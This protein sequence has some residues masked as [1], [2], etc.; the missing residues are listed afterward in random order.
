MSESRVRI[1]SEGALSADDVARRT[2]ATSRRGFDPSDVRGFLEAVAGELRRL[3][4]RIEELEG[5]GSGGPAP[6]HHESTAAPALDIATLTTALG[7]ETARVLRTAQEAA[8]DVRARAEEGAA[9]ALA[10]AHDEAARIRAAAETLLAQRTE[11][12]DAMAAKLRAE[13]ET[14]VGALKSRAESETEAAIQAAI[15]RGREMVGEAQA[16]RERMLTDLA[17]RRRTALGQLEMLRAGRDRLLAAY[18]SVRSSLEEVTAQLEQADDG[19]PEIGTWSAVAEH[20]VAEH[21]VAELAPPPAAPTTELAPPEPDAVAVPPV[22]VQPPAPAVA[23][24]PVTPGDAMPVAALP[25]EAVGAPPS[26]PEPATG[27]VDELF[28]RMRADRA[29][30]T[31]KALETLADPH[32]AP[33]EAQPDAV[34]SD[35]PPVSDTDEGLL[36]RRDELVNPLASELTKKL[37]RLLQDEQNVVLDRLRTRKGKL[38]ADSILSEVGTHAGPYAKEALRILEQ[39]QR[40][41][42]DLAASVGDTHQAAAPEG[43]ALRALADGLAFELLEPLRQ[44]LERSISEGGDD[45]S[46]ATDAVNSA[47]REMKSRRIERAVGDRLTGALTL[48]MAQVLPAGTPVR[49]LVDDAD[50][51]CPDCDDNALAGALPL[52]EAFP[53][54]QVG[55]P[56]HPGCRCL[57]GPPS[58]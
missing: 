29:E 52:G 8:V 54:G 49:W 12:A 24:E 47:Y 33:P 30:S 38:T 56:A 28:A 22:A 13:V 17:R 10:E 51:P 46:A 53:T 3:H 20:A 37:K 4:Q 32:E 2:F 31:V 48:G 55:P 18:Q 21:A 39:A 15:E 25:D 57:L 36:Q 5:P 7:E 16:A 6:A 50:G 11:E 35:G 42:A 58:A 9:R 43:D 26:S 1:G 44:R 19:A 40:A 45:Q 27:N 34:S 23:P 14:E 41:G